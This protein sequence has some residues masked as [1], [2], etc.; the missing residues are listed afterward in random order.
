MKRIWL[1]VGILL[2]LLVLGILVIHT[3]DRQLGKIAETLEQASEAQNWEEAVSLAQKA[4][5]DW[6]QKR[7]LMATLA[8]H[9]GLDEIDGLFAETAVYQK[10][11]AE[12]DHA[13]VCAQLSESIRALE[14]NHSLSLWNLL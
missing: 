11:R 14:E 5:L 12:T 9:A 13:A 10:R 3:V 8:D 2:G 4:R 7:K 1:G 6:D